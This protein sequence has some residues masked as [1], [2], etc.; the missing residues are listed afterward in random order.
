MTP[1]ETIYHN[2]GVEIYPSVFR[3][4]SAEIAEQTKKQ[5]GVKFIP[6]EYFI[7]VQNDK[8][9]LVYELEDSDLPSMYWSQFENH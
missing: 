8:I 2:G 9:V 6:T 4:A 1:R 3:L 5:I 7:S